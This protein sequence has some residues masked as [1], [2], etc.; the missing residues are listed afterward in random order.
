MN[1]EVNLVPA[2]N[3]LKRIIQQMTEDYKRTIKPYQD[4]LIALRKLNTACEF[5]EGKGWV[6]RGRAC[7]ED[8]RPDPNDPHDRIQCD[9]CKGT[10]KVV[11]K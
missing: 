2:I 11:S 7:A 10:G 8:D 6:L 4:S 3:E 1:N 5:C 9:I